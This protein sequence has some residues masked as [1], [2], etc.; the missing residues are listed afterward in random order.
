MR[1]DISSPGPQ[2]CPWQNPFDRKQATSSGSDLDLGN[3]VFTR[4]E[5]INQLGC[6][7]HQ[8]GLCDRI[9][10]Q[11]QVGVPNVVLS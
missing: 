11:A 8:L 3:R 4:E 6:C 1:S 5:G 10:V 2:S 7:E 9:N